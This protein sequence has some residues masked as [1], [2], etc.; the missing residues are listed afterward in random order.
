M[1]DSRTARSQPSLASRTSQRL[2][3]FTGASILGNAVLIVIFLR[4]LTKT[5]QH[6]STL[7]AH[8]QQRLDAQTSALDLQQQQHKL[9]LGKLYAAPDASSLLDIKD[10]LTLN[11]S[12]DLSQHVVNWKYCPLTVSDTTTHTLRTVPFCDTTPNS[13]QAYQMQWFGAHVVSGKRPSFPTY[14]NC[15]HLPPVGYQW[16]AKHNPLPAQPG[17]SSYVHWPNLRVS[18]KEELIVFNKATPKNLYHFDAP[19]YD[20]DAMDELSFAAQY[21]P[22]ADKIRLMLDVGAGGGSLGLL[23]KRK[24]DI[25]TLSTVFADWPVKFFQTH[26]LVHTKTFAPCITSHTRTSNSTSNSLTSTF[27]RLRSDAFA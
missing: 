3:Y 16:P 8:E 23:L 1:S 18:N 6:S 2:T 9:S 5:C 25:Q 10:D 24:Y 26:S 20:R 13:E 27:F 21:I 22:F 19:Q 12:F 7:L 15:I 17:D 11:T 14:M 4:S